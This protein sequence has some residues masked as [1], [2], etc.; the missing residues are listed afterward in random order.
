MLQQGLYPCNSSAWA[1]WRL[2]P[3]S[4]HIQLPRLGSKQ[5]AVWSSGLVW[6][7][8]QVTPK[9]PAQCSP[10]QAA[11]DLCSVAWTSLTAQTA[12]SHTFSSLLSFSH[13]AEQHFCHVTVYLEAPPEWLWGSAVPCTLSTEANHALC[14]TTWSLLTEA[15]QQTPAPRGMLSAI[16]KA[17]QD[18]SV[19]MTYVWRHFALEL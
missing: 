12:V 11:G 5:V 4:R 13:T 7:S 9:M 8:T 14:R 18:P 1:L 10:L 15:A 19:T 17:H 16:I 3:L 2:W 6:F